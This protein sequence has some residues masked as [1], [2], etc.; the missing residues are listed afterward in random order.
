MKNRFFNLAVA[1]AMACGSFVL[2]SCDDDD[3]N[4]SEYSYS[5]IYA[6]INMSSDVE[7]AIT[8]SDLDS[9]TISLTS[10]QSKDVYT[11]TVS[12][13]TLDANGNGQVKVYIPVGTYDIS[14]EKSANGKTIFFRKEN[15]TIKDENQNVDVTLIATVAQQSDFQFIFSEIF[16]NGERNAGRMMHPDQYMVVY[17]PTDNVLYAD[18]L[19]IGCTMQ[20]SCTEKESWY[21]EYYNAGKVPVHGIIVIP[22]T[23]Y[24]HPVKPHE[25]LVIAFN[26]INHTETE[27]SY[28]ETNE[29][30]GETT[31]VTYK[32]ENAVDLSG[33]DFEIYDP[34]LYTSDVDNPEVPNV[35]EIYP[36]ESDLGGIGGF[37]QHPR[38]FYCPFIFKLENGTQETL[39]KFKTENTSVASV[40][41]KD[42]NSVDIQMLS[43]KAADILDGITT[44][45]IPSDIVTNPLP[46][47]VDRGKQLVKGC[48]SGLLV[49]RKGNDQDGYADTNNSTE[50][51]EIVTPQHAFPAGWRNK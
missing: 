21:D 9:C 30:T 28:E 47:T 4:K 19:A 15:V 39:D 43:V 29:E 8:A 41:D 37:Y 42:G 5:G 48:H 35:L 27:G 10:T 44:G 33:A 38:G 18:G 49:Q 17:N 3:D 34:Q 31:T 14:L 40:Q 50:D 45:H 46:Q 26:A 2:A 1:L 12:K 22:G 25:K 6:F 16:F 7:G 24:E 51:C 32:Y 20:A 13:E 11:F 36:A 23:G